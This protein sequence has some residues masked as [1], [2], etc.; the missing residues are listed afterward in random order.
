[1][2]ANAFAQDKK[3]CFEAGFDDYLVKPVDLNELREHI[4]K[5]TRGAQV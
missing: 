4:Y 3:R 1:M 2:T 5:W